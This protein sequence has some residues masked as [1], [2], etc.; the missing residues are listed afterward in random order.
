MKT[1]E[2]TINHLLSLFKER[3]TDPFLRSF[4]AFFFIFNW[5]PI[6][7]LL[8]DDRGWIEKIQ[9]IALVYKFPV[10]PLLSFGAHGAVEVN[11]GLFIASLL[12]TAGPPLVLALFWILVWPYISRLFVGYVDTQG[13]KTKNLRRLRQGQSLLNKAESD[14]LRAR[15]LSLENQI[16]AMNTHLDGEDIRNLLR[17]GAALRFKTDAAHFRIY[18][19]D[20]RDDGRIATG[21]WVG[22]S[23]NRITYSPPNHLATQFGLVVIDLPGAYFMV[24]TKGT[25]NIAT[26][27]L[28]NLPTLLQGQFYRFNGDS[29]PTPIT[30]KTPLLL[31]DAWKTLFKVDSQGNLLIASEASSSG[32]TIIRAIPGS[33][34]NETPEIRE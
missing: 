5:R 25:I 7:I 14:Q 15:N 28:L 27:K 12:L 2:D 4:T 23:D 32:N 24:Q 31:E 3:A 21:N 30:P 33:P 20:S 34:I 26:Q 1:I 19:A 18:R 9:F 10:N 16:A 22:I 11:G 29:A 17:D 8:F 6:S 13:V